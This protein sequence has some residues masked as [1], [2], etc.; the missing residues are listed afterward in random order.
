MK[1]SLLMRRIYDKQFKIADIKLVFEDDMSVADVAKE[2]S[3]HYNSL[4]RW[5]NEYE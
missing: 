3:I 2:S 5:R 1:S 4:Y